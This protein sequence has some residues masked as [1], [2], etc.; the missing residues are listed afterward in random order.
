[1]ITQAPEKLSAH[2]QIRMKPQQRNWF[3]QESK[4]S[5]F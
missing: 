5:F 3:F 2:I 4:I 1:M